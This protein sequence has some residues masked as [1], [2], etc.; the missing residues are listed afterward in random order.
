[1]VSKKMYILSSKIKK[2][3][4]TRGRKNRSNFRDDCGVWE[5]GKGTT[6]KTSYLILPSGDLKKIVKR[7]NLGGLIA[8]KRKL[9][10]SCITFHLI[11]SQ[12]MMNFSIFIG[13]THI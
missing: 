9:K 8:M 10:G 7:K 4:V 3:I 1:M 11:H 5:S 6:P 13:I 2:N 12:Q